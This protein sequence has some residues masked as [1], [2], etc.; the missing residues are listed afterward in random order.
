MT[1]DV[2]S[3]TRGAIYSFSVVQRG[4]GERFKAATPYVLALVDLHGGE[5]ILTNIVGSPVEHLPVNTHGGLLSHGHPDTPAGIFHEIE[6]VKQIRREVQPGRQVVEPKVGLVSGNSGMLREM[7][8]VLLGE[9]R[10][11]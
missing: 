3:G 9:D 7:A 10:N 1:A 6:A 8:V 4:V 11:G 2:E 5:R